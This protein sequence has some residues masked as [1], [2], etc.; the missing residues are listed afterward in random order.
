[1][2]ILSDFLERRFLPASQKTPIKTLNEKIGRVIRHVVCV[3][4]SVRFRRPRS[5]D[6]TSNEEIDA[7][8]H[9]MH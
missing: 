6:D 3:I 8:S 7:C 9:G 5:S 2:L 4:Q 1:M